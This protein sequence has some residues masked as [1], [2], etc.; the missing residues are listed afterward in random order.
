[1]CA[2]CKCDKEGK[3]YVL[4][5]SGVTYDFTICDKCEKEKGEKYIDFF[6]NIR[7][8][9]KNTAENNT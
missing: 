3:K 2:I 1:M 4:A 7:A 8:N 9:L 5:I 6:D